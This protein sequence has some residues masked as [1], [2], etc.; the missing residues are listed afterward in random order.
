M[1]CIGDHLGVRAETSGV[2]TGAMNP[3]PDV[4]TA[5]THDIEASGEAADVVACLFVRLL[6]SPR[7]L[8]GPH[9]PSGRS[10]DS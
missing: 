2:G 10:S 9:L 3:G 8:E 5:S 6:W 4:Y 1:H 7:A